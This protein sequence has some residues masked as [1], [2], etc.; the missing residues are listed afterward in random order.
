MK[1]KFAAVMLSALAA[2]LLGL[3][4]FFVACEGGTESG[5]QDTEQGGE[6]GGE[7]GDEEQGD[8]EETQEPAYTLTYELT[9]DYYTVTGIESA[10]EAAEVVI[11]S[12]YQGVPVRAVA[13]HAFWGKTFITEIEIPGALPRSGTMPFR[14]CTALSSVTI[15][16]GASGFERAF[17]LNC[18][19][20]REATVPASAVSLLPK[21][22]QTL[23]V[24][25][26]TIGAGALAGCAQLTSLTAPAVGVLGGLFGDTKG[27]P[28]VFDAIRTARRSPPRLLPVSPRSARSICRKQSRRSARARSRARH[29]LQTRQ[30]GGSASVISGS[31][32]SRRLPERKGTVPSGKGQKSLPTRCSKI[33]RRLRKFASGKSDHDRRVC[34]QRLRRAHGDR[35]PRKRRANREI[36]FS[37]CSALTKVNYNAVSAAD[38]GPGAMCFT[39][40]GALRAVLPSSLGRA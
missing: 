7:T 16:D 4:V 19:G 32:C 17:F 15:G 21:N 14:I 29:I 37:G 26:G 27:V 40:R 33:V 30:I 25:S 24:T 10:A 22:L 12:S 5:G 1:R 28:A 31:I 38:L 39:E 6:T 11:P 3:S 23:T 13:P 36:A 8:G 34:I 2:L 18:T 9:G 35:D 20:I